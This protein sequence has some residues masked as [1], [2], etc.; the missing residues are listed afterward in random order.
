MLVFTQSQY[1]SFFSM[2]AV[3]NKKDQPVLDFTHGSLR[4][5]DKTQSFS[6]TVSPWKVVLLG[7]MAF[8]CCGTAESGFS[9]KLG[10]YFTYFLQP[11]SYW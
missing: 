10:K 8:P 5:V 11:Q 2:F 3:L 4:W 6:S 9:D 7:H 1:L